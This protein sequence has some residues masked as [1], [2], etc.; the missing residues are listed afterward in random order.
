MGEWPQLS[1]AGGRGYWGQNP[2]NRVVWAQLSLTYGG[3]GCF[4]AGG[5]LFCWE[6]IS[7]I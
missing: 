5:D 4:G 3:G 7:D 6:N 2:E 1:G